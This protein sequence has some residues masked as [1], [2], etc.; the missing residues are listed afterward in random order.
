MIRPI[1]DYVVID[2]PR[3]ENVTRGGVLLPTQS[4]RKKPTEGVV[5]ATGPGKVHPVSGQRLPMQCAVG[6]R[7]VFRQYDV[8]KAKEI[9]EA[10]DETG[11][12]YIFIRDDEV[13]MII[14]NDCKYEPGRNEHLRD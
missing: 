4:G 2:R 10:C 7:V 9:P 13:L 14:P 5:I 8:Q 12:P 6:D 11:K 1:N 3:S